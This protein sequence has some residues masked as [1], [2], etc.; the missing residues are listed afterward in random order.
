MGSGAEEVEA[1][2]RGSGTVCGAQGERE[3]V[4]DTI[5]PPKGRECPAM[6]LSGSRR[7]PGCDAGRAA[8]G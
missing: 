2:E 7:G 3:T 4:P 1:K 5:S 8:K 6:G